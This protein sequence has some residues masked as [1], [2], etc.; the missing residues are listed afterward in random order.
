MGIICVQKDETYRDQGVIIASFH[1]PE[2]LNAING[3]F[4]EELNQMLDYVLEQKDVNTLVLA[5]EIEKAF[6]T[7]VDVAYVQALTNDAAVDFFVELAKLLERI[8]S[9]PK[10][11]VAAV[12]GYAYGGGADLAL[13]CDIRIGNETSSFRFPGPQFGLV[14]GTKRLLAE[15]GPAKS[16]FLTLTNERIHAEKAL[17]YGIIQELVSGSDIFTH[18]LKRAVNIAFIPKFTAKCIK[19]LTNEENSSESIELTRESVREG[20][21]RQR[22]TNYV[23]R[24]RRSST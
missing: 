1:R 8:V 17:E 22:F 12:N 21:F 5:S 4:I 19:Q 3:T 24:M 15:V 18:T 16:R 6:C 20:D 9:F 7:G 23:E 11:T 14:L 10:T 13:A 2:T